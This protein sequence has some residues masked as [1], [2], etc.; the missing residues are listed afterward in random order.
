MTDS[1][2]TIVRRE[3]AFWQSMVDKD[4]DKGHLNIVE[5]VA[6]SGARNA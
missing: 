3:T 6:K 4:A 5:E 2:D 1:S